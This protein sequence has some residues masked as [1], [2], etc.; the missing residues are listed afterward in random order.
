MNVLD[1]KMICPMT[2]LR[3]NVIMEF[4][5]KGN[6]RIF[7]H[8]F[9]INQ[10]YLQE[11][12]CKTMKDQTD[13]FFFFIQINKKNDGSVIK[14]HSIVKKKEN[15][16][17]PFR[18][19]NGHTYRICYENHQQESGCL[20][21]SKT[22]TFPIFQK[23]EIFSLF[24]AFTCKLHCPKRMLELGLNIMDH[25]KSSR[26]YQLACFCNTDLCNGVITQNS[27][28]LW[29]VLTIGFQ[30]WDCFKNLQMKTCL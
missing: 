22:T 23:T 29:M 5:L 19:K 30:F 25:K 24:Q 18:I 20:E 13:F 28:Y 27:T 3:K 17:F 6:E 16:L 14:A 11:N 10:S 12:I 26:E 9:K 7:C 8:L 15:S 2:V 21:V 1:H 4:V